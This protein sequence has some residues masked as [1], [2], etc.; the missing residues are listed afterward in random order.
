MSLEHFYFTPK[1]ITQGIE[2]IRRM[3]SLRTIG[4]Y[5]AGGQHFPPEVFWKKYD[6]GEF[7]Q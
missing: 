6:A 5:W 4:V 7:N 2:G 1:N 3:K